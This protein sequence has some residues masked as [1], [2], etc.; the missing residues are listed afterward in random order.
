VQLGFYFILFFP[1]P[2]SEKTRENFV[3]FR[4]LFRHFSKLKNKFKLPTHRP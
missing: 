1:S 4:D 3:L 2:E